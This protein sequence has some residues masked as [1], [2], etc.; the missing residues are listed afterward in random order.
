MKRTLVAAS[1]VLLLLAAGSAAHGATPAGGVLPCAG[2]L[3]A[4]PSFERGTEGWDAGP[5]VVVSDTAA[6]PAHTGH[7]LA[8]FA[9]LDATHADRLRSS[10]VTLP[11]GCTLTVALWIRVTS[12]ET[13]QGDYL[14]FGITVTGILPKTYRSFHRGDANPAWV[15][16]SWSVAPA[17]TDRTASVGFYGSESAGGGVTSFE[18]DDITLTLG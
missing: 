6:R 2:Q 17:A 5:R 13:L 12:T 9:G 15:R 7:Q 8:S 16:H 1:T 3:H 18:V 10:S 11:A 14:N 4:N